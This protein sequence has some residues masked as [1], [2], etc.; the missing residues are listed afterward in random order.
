MYPS[1]VVNTGR[2]IR[3][4]NVCS[5]GG[6]KDRASNTDKTPRGRGTRT[7]TRQRGAEESSVCAGDSLHSISFVAVHHRAGSGSETVIQQQQQKKKK[8]KK[9]D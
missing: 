1:S 6:E 7:T 2:L 9:E 3:V 4:D 5:V 8:T